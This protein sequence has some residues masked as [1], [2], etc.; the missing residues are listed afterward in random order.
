MILAAELYVNLNVI[1]DLSHAASE[2]QMPDYL[3][4]CL[5]YCLEFCR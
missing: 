5:V 2:I 4:M 3:S 1:E